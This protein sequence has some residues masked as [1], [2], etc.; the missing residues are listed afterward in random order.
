[1]STVYLETQ[2]AVES[3]DS[4]QYRAVPAAAIIGLVLGVFSIVTL[5]AAATARDSSLGSSLLVAPIPVLGIIMS[6]RA[7]AKI[8]READFY[9]GEK[10][11]VAGAALSAFFLVVGVGYGAF[12]HA[13]EVPPDHTRI[14][15]INMRPDINQ[16]RAGV[17]VPPEI[18]ALDGQKVFIKGYMRPPEMLR[19]IERFLLVRD[20]NQCCFGDIST[21]K[22]YDR[23]LVNMTGSK[24][25]NYSDG[26]FAMGGV[27]RV[28]PQNAA[29]G[30]EAPV[31]ALIADYAN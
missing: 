27:L 4:V 3:A 28:M 10:L 20:N 23:I 22:Y 6:L 29:L 16:E 12:V 1:M 31:F 11:A 21:V 15:F 25:L 18:L 2:D 17:V 24:R 13:T 5:I 8:R 26:V 9:S 7:L 14:S 30:P 19:G